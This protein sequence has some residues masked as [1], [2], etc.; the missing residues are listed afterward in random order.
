MFVYRR[1]AIRVHEGE[2]MK[3]ILVVVVVLVVAIAASTYFKVYYSADGAGA[4]LY[5]RGDEAYL[6]LGSGHTGYSCRYIQCLI[7]H[8]LQYFN[9]V[10]EPEHEVRSVLVLRITPTGIERQVVNRGTHHW[11]G[12]VTP[13]EDGFYGMCEGTVLC[14]LSG[15]DF[16]SATEE[17]QKKHDGL[18][19]L[20]RDD[21]NDKTI[22]G[23]YV[24]GVRE[25]TD[26]F[27]LNVGG[28]FTIAAKN[29]ATDARQ[30]PNVAVDLIR[31]GHAPENLYHVDGTPRTVSRAEYDRLMAEH[32]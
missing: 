22:N 4:T 18:N 32:R 20:M 31:P 16:V 29:L 8:A 2:T 10:P 13:F 27:E 9:Y 30:Y 24:R 21:M 23:W 26:H 5:S 3:T 7:I 1:A 19:R 17:E 6:F 11:P 28:K 15:N 12:F 25:A 14:K